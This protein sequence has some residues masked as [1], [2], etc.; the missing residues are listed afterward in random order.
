MN[1]RTQICR[2]AG[3]PLVFVLLVSHGGGL[4]AELIDFDLN[5]ATGLDWGGETIK[6][7]GNE[8]QASHGVQMGFGPLGASTDVTRMVNIREGGPS[9]N[10]YGSPL[11][12]DALVPGDPSGGWFISSDDIIP[13]PTASLP[14]FQ[15]RF[16]NP[17]AFF[18]MNI[19]DL[20]QGEAWQ[21]RAYNGSFQLLDTIDLNSSGSPGPA[22]AASTYFQFDRSFAEI[23]GIQVQYTGL[24][25][26][27][28]FAFDRLAFFDNACSRAGNGDFPAFIMWHCDASSAFSI[29]TGRICLVTHVV[30]SDEFINFEGRV[31]MLRI[32]KGV[33]TIG[34]FATT[35]VSHAGMVDFE[36]LPYGTLSEGLGI[37]NQYRISQGMSFSL[38]GGGSPVI[39][40]RGDQGI[41]AAAFVSSSLGI[42]DTLNDPVIGGDFFLADDLTNGNI[43]PTLIVDLMSPM[44]QFSM[45]IYDVESRADGT[46]EAWR[47]NFFDSGDNLIDFIDV[48]TSFPLTSDGVATPVSFTAVGAIIKRVEVEYTGTAVAPGIGWDDFSTSAT[49]AVPEPGSIVLVSMMGLGGLAVRRKKRRSKMFFNIQSRFGVSPSIE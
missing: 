10:A 42:P 43:P 4:S 3:I 36:S 6:L 21:I 47:L 40:E 29:S 39:V 33:F 1:F 20:D 9:G 45:S 25:S 37:S 32:L 16:S 44:A 12:E 2:I 13:T 7:S 30:E 49:A 14:T 46:S 22:D 19:L 18:G 34:M 15:V 31:W 11:G 28:G 26:T 38:M 24:A 48:D 17:Q 35:V 41:G 27:A 5:P 8:W 23:V